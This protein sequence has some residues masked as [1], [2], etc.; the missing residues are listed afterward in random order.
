MNFTPS[1]LESLAAILIRDLTANLNGNAIAPYL[2]ALRQGIA[3][4]T[5]IRTNELL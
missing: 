2:N 4:D 3:V 1:E 5:S